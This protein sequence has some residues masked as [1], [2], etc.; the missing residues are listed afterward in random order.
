MKANKL[1]D[2]G[3]IVMQFLSKFNHDT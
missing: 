1:V 2:V 3:I